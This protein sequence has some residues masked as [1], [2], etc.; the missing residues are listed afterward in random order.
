MRRAALAC[1]LFLLSAPALFAQ[2][3]PE[4][5]YPEE[6]QLLYPWHLPRVAYQGDYGNGLGRQ[7][8]LSA[9]HFFLP[10][11]GEQERGAVLF[12]DARLLF[13]HEI[14][15]VSGSVGA[16]YRR[17]LPLI[18]GAFGGYL[19]YDNGPTSNNRFRVN[20]ASFGFDY[21]GNVCDARANFYIPFGPTS[22][23]VGSTFVLDRNPEFTGNFMLVNGGTNTRFFD[24]ALGGGDIEVGSRFY[25]DDKVE[26]RGFVGAYYYDAH[27]PSGAVG[28]KLRLEARVFDHAALN[29][30]I[31]HDNV[32]KTT[33][34]L[35]VTIT[36]PRYTGRR[37]DDGPPAPL[38]PID[39]VAEPVV[40]TPQVVVQRQAVTNQ[41]AR[42]LAIDP[43][44][45][46]PMFFLHVAP[47]GNGNGTFE[48]PFGTLA[49]AFATPR[50]AA[51][52]L[53]VY[54]TNH[55]TFT[56]NVNL[57]PGT[58]LLSNAPFQ[59]VLTTNAG[60]VTLP[61]S[62]ASPSL[63][64]TPSINGTITL[65]N[66]TTVSGFR[67]NPLPGATGVSGPATGVVTNVQV[68]NNVINSGSAGVNIND[69][70][71]TVVVSSNFING[72]TTN[73][74]SIGVQNSP[75]ANIVVLG[76]QITSP[77]QNGVQVLVNT[78]AGTNSSVQAN[79]SNNIIN[80]AGNNGIALQN[81]QSSTL[82][83]QVS[84]NSVNGSGNNGLG[85]FS[86]NGS[87]TVRVTAVGNLFANSAGPDALADYS[88][89][90][91]SNVILDFNGNRAVP[92]GYD[93]RQAGGATVG[94]VNLPTF[95]TRNVGPL[96]TT[97]TIN[98]VPSP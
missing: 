81:D 20:Q 54:D 44:T 73:A 97:G 84:S 13:L 6:E 83:A 82:Q 12:G 1:V 9:F 47:G 3:Y 15:A 63:S 93:F 22:R 40:R 70:A 23:F 29:V 96:T 88:L 17:Y 7:G 85:L 14:G 39:R 19:Y 61:F 55:D 10:A 43:L 79:V 98:N 30:S 62:G 86:T 35:G 69:A 26:L 45:G 11:S 68:D 89:G 78:L 52:N 49:Q 41:V 32:F 59:S 4:L 53:V 36:F 57:A 92:N 64:S 8:G 51:G 16:G 33:V 76:N 31:Q 80:G 74:V 60:Y 71:G 27:F 46:R 38:T 95:T 72:P 90:S 77:G 94:V 42:E 18:D 66:N 5:A 37:Y 28:P 65:A 25:A 91:S 67:I 24:K 75:S 87:N 34:N 58:R 50:F 48:N 2:A 21:L 56:G